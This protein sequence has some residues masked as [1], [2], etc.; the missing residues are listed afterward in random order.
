MSNR[1][2]IDGHDR[3]R[4]VKPLLLRALTFAL[5]ACAVLICADL[6]WDRAVPDFTT[7][8]L[9]L[10]WVFHGATVVLATLG[11]LMAF[12]ETDECDRTFARAFTT[13][14]LFGLVSTVGA[15]AA[16]LV[17]DEPG[18]AMWLLVGSAVVALSANWFS[19]R[20]KVVPAPKGPPPPKPSR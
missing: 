5:A 3:G 6:W 12:K 10:H 11:S 20:A 14:L 9:G 18:V 2:D 13:G 4:R 19:N 7:R 16:Y 15:V 17:G 1:F 8:V